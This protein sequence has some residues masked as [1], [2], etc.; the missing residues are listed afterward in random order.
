M[1][2]MLSREEVL[3]GGGGIG[4]CSGQG[5]EQPLVSSGAHRHQESTAQQEPLESL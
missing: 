4:A 3:G 2:G 1:R 5:P